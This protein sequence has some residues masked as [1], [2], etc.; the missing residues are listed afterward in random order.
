M[1]SSWPPHGLQH[2]W[3]SCP[4]FPRICSYSRPLSGWCYL[5]ITSSADP[6]SFYFHSFPAS[7]SFQ[8]SQLFPS[9]GQSIGASAS[10]SVLPM[11]I[12]GWFPLELIGLISLQPKR[13]SRVFSSTIQKHQFFS[14]PGGSNCKESACNAGELV[15]IPGSG[16]SPVE[17]MATHSSIL[18]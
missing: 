3:L 14:F 12:Q 6:F 2:T 9:S 4:L 15:S 17:G 8:M 10:A 13:L 7:G 16:R 11:N 1:S 18:D 5:T